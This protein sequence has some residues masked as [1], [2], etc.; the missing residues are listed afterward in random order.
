MFGYKQVDC[1]L[2]QMKLPLLI[3]TRN[4]VFIQIE[5]YDMLGSVL[6]KLQMIK[7]LWHYN[8]INFICVLRI[9]Q[10]SHVICTNANHVHPACL[11]SSI[12]GVCV[13]NLS[14][15][16]VPDFSLLDNY[17]WLFFVA[18]TYE[19]IENKFVL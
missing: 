10:V 8:F 7:K 12:P 16:H 4:L 6:F 9:V 13:T 2:K 11:T 19:I 15:R 14:I 17:F 18:T 1:L 5:I 3:L